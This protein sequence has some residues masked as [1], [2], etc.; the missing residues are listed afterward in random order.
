MI[1]PELERQLQAIKSEKPFINTV[2]KEL[3]KIVASGNFSLK[4]L[5]QKLGLSERT[6]QRKLNKEHTTF[7]AEL[8][9][10]QFEMAIFFA[11]QENQIIEEIAY[12]VGYSEASAFSRAL[13]KWSGVTFK[14]YIRPSKKT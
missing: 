10:V 13:K 14:E 12:L 2:H 3:Q 1:A 9:A 8:Q 6:L 11:T 5:S 7:K 4:I